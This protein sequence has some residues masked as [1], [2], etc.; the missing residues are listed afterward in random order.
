M[1]V[2]WAACLVDYRLVSIT[3]ILHFL[4]WIQPH[5]SRRSTFWYFGPNPGFYPHLDHDLH[6]L[7]WF[8]QKGQYVIRNRP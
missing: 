4:C 5:T 7:V 3:G 8:F 1:K 6:F 2:V